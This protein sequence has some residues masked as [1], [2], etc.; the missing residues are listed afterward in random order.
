MKILIIDDDDI[1]VL[2]NSKVITSIEK[3][4]EIVDFEDGELALNYLHEIIDNPDLLPDI[5]LLDLNMPVMD[6]WEFLAEYQKIL[7]KIAKKIH[8]YLLSSS[9]S[10]Y[11]MEKSQQIPEVTEFVTKPLNKET[12]N[13]IKSRFEAT[14]AT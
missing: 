9:I 14:S 2:L 5:I 8:L 4:V 3:N 13:Q 10:P 1:F 12:F 7:P 11:D 6:G